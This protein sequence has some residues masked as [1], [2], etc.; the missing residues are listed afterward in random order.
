MTKFD[1]VLLTVLTLLVIALTW[2][3]LTIERPFFTGGRIT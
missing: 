1:V 2:Y 3:S